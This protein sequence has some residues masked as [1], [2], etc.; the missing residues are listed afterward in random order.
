MSNLI[1]SDV[2]YLV[3]AISYYG[4]E[5]KNIQIEINERNALWVYEASESRP[6][7]REKALHCIVE[8][9][10]F[11]SQQKHIYNLPAFL[12]AE[13]IQ[14]VGVNTKYFLPNNDDIEKW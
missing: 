9:F 7:L 6:D 11:V 13:I 14:T 4:L 12:L 8:N 3:S 1:D 5:E 2:F 10:P